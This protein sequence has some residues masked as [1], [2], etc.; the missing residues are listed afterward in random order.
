MEALKEGQIKE[1]MI[2]Q[3]AI[4]KPSLFLRVQIVALPDISDARISRAKKDLEL[5]LPD[6]TLDFVSSDP[7]AV[8][9]LSGGT[10][11]RS[12]EIISSKTNI[13]LL[14]FP[15]EN[16]YASASEV[17][18]YLGNKGVRSWLCNLSD[19][20]MVDQLKR[21]ISV[22]T[23]VRSFT[24]KR[25]G[26]IGKVS[27][28]LVFSNPKPELLKARFGIRMKVFPWSDFPKMKSFPHSNEFLEFFKGYGDSQ[29]EEHSRVHYLIEKVIDEYQLDGVAVECFSILQDADETACLSLAFLNQ[30]GIPA[31][32]EGDLVS[33]TG[34]LLVKHLTGL[35]PWMA[36]LSG[37]YS[38]RVEFSHCTIAPM[39]LENYK[40]ETHFETGKGL[41]VSGVL[42]SEVY[43]ILRFD[44]NFENAFISK[45]MNDPQEW[46]PFACR[47][48]LS[49]RIED[50]DIKKMQNSPL[51]NHHLIIP[52]D[53]I[54]VFRI[55]CEYLNVTV[56]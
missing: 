38:D 26:L 34:M 15:R 7:L 18:A 21:F 41:A 23:R 36:N 22:W 55:A 10:E 45:G 4:D 37:L 13:I 39:Y 53:Y 48:Q 11:K 44:Q 28:W 46:K 19:E 12:L 40:L 52:G 54:E 29:L 6:I 51:G 1:E 20:R 43:T 9:F 30:K 25:I 56:I 47:A 16:A 42:S 31:A 14:A 24:H 17:K 8:F 32:C 49:L 5:A 33:L 27:D 3:K 35:I 50:S 2:Q